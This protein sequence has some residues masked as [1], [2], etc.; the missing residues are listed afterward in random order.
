[1]GIAYYIVVY[2][3]PMLRARFWVQFATILVVLYVGYYIVVHIPPMLRAR[4]WVQFATILVVLYIAY[5]IAVYI[6]P[7][8]RARFWLNADPTTNPKN[9]LFLRILFYA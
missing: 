3:P 2:I 7:M 1:M 8:L 5:Y 4:F 6:P 9:F